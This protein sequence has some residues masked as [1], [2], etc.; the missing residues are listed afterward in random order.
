M[1][2]KHFSYRIT[3]PLLFTASS[4]WCYSPFHWWRSNVSAS[5]RRFAQG[6]CGNGLCRFLVAGIFTLVPITPVDS[7][8]QFAVKIMIVVVAAN[9]TGVALYRLRKRRRLPLQLNKAGLRSNPVIN[10]AAKTRFGSNPKKET[11]MGNINMGRVISAAW[12]PA[13]VLNI[14]EFLLKWNWL[15]DQMK[16]S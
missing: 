3:L 13:L 12:S 9:A 16:P 15:A 7:R 5:R 2:K 10:P 8:L 4:T 14:G 11:E 1:N 6:G